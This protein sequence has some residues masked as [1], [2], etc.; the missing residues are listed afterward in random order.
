MATVEEPLR[1]PFLKVTSTDHGAWVLLSS[2]L[3]LILAI[4]V[5]AVTLISRFRVL[6]KIVCCDWLILMSSIFFIAQ[7]TFVNIACKNGLGRHRDTLDEATFQSFSKSIYV[8]QI[9][10]VVA[11]AATKASVALLIIRIR[12][13]KRVL[14]A[15]RGLLAVIT[16]WLAAGVISLAFQ[17]NV[18]RPWIFSDGRCLN[19]R[20]LY[21]G[22]GVGSILTDISLVIIPFFL[23]FQVQLPTKKRLTIASFFGTKIIVPIFT[24]VTLSTQNPYFDT[25]PPDNTWLAVKPTIW[26]QATICLSLITTCLPSLK[27]VMADFQTGLMAGTV[28][29]Y[30]EFSISGGGASCAAVIPKTLVS[31]PPI[32]EKRAA[33]N[34]SLGDGTIDDTD[35]GGP[36]HSGRTRRRSSHGHG[37]EGTAYMHSITHIRGADQPCNTTTITGE[38]NTQNPQENVDGV[39]NPNNAIVQT[40]GYEVRYDNENNEGEQRTSNDK[41]GDQP[42][43]AG[44]SKGQAINDPSNM[45]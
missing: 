11:L 9:L 41:A 37:V 33:S 27:R 44:P 2:T 4:M 32:P 19:L 3:L 1:P 38:N 42:P 6:G 36:G 35:S 17:C 14:Q 5:A 7:S 43:N 8:S 30:F 34:T 26:A 24:T 18:P 23:V 25:T 28:T 31:R 12:P 20:A 13:L 22:L 29:E 21:I 16:V 40:I 10:S 45:C 15:C 39:D